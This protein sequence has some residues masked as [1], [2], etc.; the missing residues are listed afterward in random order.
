MA[1]LPI[2]VSG[3]FVCGAVLLVGA[4]VAAAADRWPESRRSAGLGGI[5]LGV[6]GGN[7]GWVL[8]G[9]VSGLF[10]FVNI[11]AGLTA[12]TSTLVWLGLEGWRTEGSAE[13]GSTQQ[14]RLDEW[15]TDSQEIATKNGRDE[16]IT[17]G[18]VLTLLAPVAGTLTVTFAAGSLPPVA[19][20]AAGAAV[21]LAC[22]VPA[23]GNRW[24]AA[25]G[26]L[27]LLG[28]GLYLTGGPPGG[29]YGQ[30]TALA[31]VGFG[32]LGLGLASLRW[33]GKHLTKRLAARAGADGEQAVAVWQFVSALGGLLTI[34][35]TTITVHEKATRYGGVAGV[36][37]ISFTLGLVG[38][39]I[40][41]P[42]WFL[43]DG[44]DATIVAFVGATLAAFWTLETARS[45]GGFAKA[46]WSFYRWAFTLPLRAVKTLFT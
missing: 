30:S 46:V 15:S 44:V 19:G 29:D 45:V 43:E 1:L 16:W 11:V 9:P 38:V 23:S 5:L 24:F 31:C 33:L 34:I 25:V 27:Y 18:Q 40:P 41:F 37:T 12:G 22:L 42:V 3:A 8:T 26:S 17:D 2:V 28:T 20:I 6:F 14:R 32:M 13:G 4:V 35:W 7:V 39:E 21:A 10:S 36:G